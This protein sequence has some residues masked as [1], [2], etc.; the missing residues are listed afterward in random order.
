[1]IYLPRR[2]TEILTVA[3]A[4]LVLLVVGAVLFAWSGI[5]NVAASS[6][7]W[8][9]VEF[10]LRFTMQNSVDRRAAFID[11]PPLDDDDLILLGAGAYHSNCAW[12]HGAPGMPR[13]PVSHSMLPPP[14]DLSKEM[15]NWD[16]A[17]LFWIVKHG[18]KYTGMPAW[19]SQQRDDE[20]WALAAFLR[21]IKGLDADAYRGLALGIAKSE[22]SGEEIATEEGAV[23]AAVACIR[24]HGAEDRGPR[25]ALVPTLH[26]QNVEFL[27]E[28][29]NAYAT[30]MRESGVMQPIANDLSPADIKRV[31]QYYSGLAPPRQAARPVRA[32]GNPDNGRRIAEEGVPEFDIP[33]CLT[34]HGDDGLS[35]YPRLA[36]QSARYIVTQLHL[37]QA[38][39]TRHTD[40]AAIMTPIARRLT[41]EQIADVAAYLASLRW[42]V[43]PSQSP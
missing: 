39:T 18:I 1:M 14:P 32:N 20:V 36:G 2:W 24:C 19:P 15:R 38:T 16:D 29:L 34:C 12:C 21:Q 3:V 13:N 22:Q 28:A 7:H 30:G 9:V 37:W 27:V 5:F 23:E 35:T 41:D 10:F 33:P 25:S 40:G 8:K 43:A 26:G 4:G 31:A 11:P 42:P 6:G 17:E